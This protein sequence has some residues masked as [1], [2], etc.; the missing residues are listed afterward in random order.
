[1]KVKLIRPLDGRPIGS[2]VDYPDEDAKRLEKS[3][4][5]SFFAEKAAPEPANKMAPAVSNKA[6]PKSRAKK[7]S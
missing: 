5:V 6:A 3:G 2:V 4:V 7:V 1:M